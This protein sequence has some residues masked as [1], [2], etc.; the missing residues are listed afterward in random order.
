[1]NISEIN[2]NTLAAHSID[3]IL[4]SRNLINF[5]VLEYFIF[6]FV[7]RAIILYINED[8]CVSTII[9]TKEI[10]GML[11]KPKQTMSC[12]TL[13]NCLSLGEFNTLHLWASC[14]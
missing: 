3:I 10:P 4:L 6:S 12:L 2:P 14:L 11:I 8:R 13:L 9:F 1:M 7:D 5:Y